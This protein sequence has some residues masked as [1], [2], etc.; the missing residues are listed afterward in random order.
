MKKITL[1]II[2][3]LIASASFSQEKKQD[4]LVFRIEM[5]STTFKNCI[6]LIIENIDGRTATGKILIQNI[7]APF[8]QN[9]KLVPREKIVADKPKK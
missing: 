1:F 2:A 6:Q 3:A 8:Y 5:D 7:L 4:S 9:I